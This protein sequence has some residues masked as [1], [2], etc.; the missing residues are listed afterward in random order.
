M[1]REA[2]KKTPS[3][4]G[5]SICFGDIPSDLHSCGLK[6]HLDRMEGMRVTDVFGD[7][8]ETWIDFEYR[9][10]EFSAHDNFG[11]YWLW[12]QNDCPDD[13]LL[14]VLTYCRTA[15]PL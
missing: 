11:N 8:V 4:D 2:L 10:Y 12:A 9:G 3:A 13:V 6:K 15:E 14:A 5:R 1:E 7:I